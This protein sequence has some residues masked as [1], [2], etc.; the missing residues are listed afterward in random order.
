MRALILTLALG[1]TTLCRADV[2]TITFDEATLAGAPGDELDFTGT[3]TNNTADTVFIN[4][5]SF[6]FAIAGLDDSPFLNNAP[7][8]LDP[9]E[10][11]TPF[12][13]FD[14]VIPSGTPNGSYAG[15]FT[16]VGG[17]DGNAQDNLTTSSF[18]VTATPEPSTIF[19]LL[20]L[21][22]VMIFRGARTRACRVGTHADAMDGH[23]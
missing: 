3:L 22:S 13:L 1:L 21:S 14:V 2:L 4:S 6:T 8:S 18:S 23:E 7:I 9:G 17:S 10:S 19:T 5:D 16:V 20:A 12:E 15:A 11:S